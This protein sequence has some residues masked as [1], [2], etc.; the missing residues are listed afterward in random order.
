MDRTTVWQD[1]EGRPI[2]QP[3]L[4]LIRAHDHL[5]ALHNLVAAWREANPQPLVVEHDT[6]RREDVYRRAAIMPPPASIVL[7]LGDAIQCLRSA[8]DHAIYAIAQPA[9]GLEQ[10]TEFPIF[11]HERDTPNDHSRNDRGFI[12]GTGKLK[13]MV[14][15]EIYQFLSGQQPYNRTE[16]PPETHPLWGLYMLANLDKHRTIPLLVTVT[17]PWV[18]E[19]LRRNTPDEA[20]EPRVLWHR[21]AMEE[22]DPVVTVPF[23]EQPHMALQPRVKVEIVHRSPGFPEMEITTIGVRLYNYVAWAVGEL[24]P[25]FREPQP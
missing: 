5:Q 13:K 25:F 9:S 16:G 4:K 20:P 11:L 7:T 23:A 10:Y 6:E 19:V 1:A 22:G 14:P 18:V 12:S 24:E 15:G 8:L 3:R 21:P 2:A 17:R